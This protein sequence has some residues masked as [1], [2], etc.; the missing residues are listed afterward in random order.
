[1]TRILV[2]IA[3]LACLGLSGCSSDEAA[4]PETRAGDIRTNDVWKDGVELTGAV[5]IYPG[6]TVDIA[7]GATVKC[8]PGIRVIV[9][10]T[11]RKAAG[12]RSKI[13]CAGDGWT[14]L[15]V[16]Q[17]GKIELEGF[18]IENASVG[19]ETT[20]GAGD[21]TL[22]DT[23]IKNSVRPFL[24]GK[25]SKLTL[26]KVNAIAPRTPPADTVSISDV[27]GVLVASR[28][29]YDAGPNEGVSI[30]DGGEATIEDSRIYGSNGFDMVSTYGAKSLKLSYSILS[31][32][33]CGPH[34]E[35]V[36]SFTI[37]HVTSEKNT[38][39]LTIFAAG[40]G[41]NI[42]KDSNISGTAA[43]LDL[44]GEHGPLTFENVY[45]SG[46]KEQIQNTSPPTLGPKPTA[47]I[48]GAGPR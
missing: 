14:G 13:S 16:A 39:G 46:G 26:T 4:A 19:I 25:K 37:D 8:S 35:G 29:E 5:S 3:G 1:M 48:S 41:P 7:A 22:T 36:D 6:S 27:K 34:I 40:A 42:V 33:H 47:P 15:V 21:S 23:T 30:K 17:G 43:W 11:L 9:G 45:Y 12:A 2:S 18:D 10:G 20:E 44:Q 31:G 38:Y 32:A 28:L 24:V